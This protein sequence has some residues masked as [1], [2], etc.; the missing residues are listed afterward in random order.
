MKVLR[1]GDPH[2]TVR[3]LDEAL[4]LLAFIFEMARKYK[5][6]RIEFLGDLMHTHA[7]IRVEVLDFWAKAFKQLGEEFAEAD[8]RTQA[9]GEV[10]VR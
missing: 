7:V 3:N 4:K 8:M 2:I 5:V 1:V 6:D 10:A 9:K